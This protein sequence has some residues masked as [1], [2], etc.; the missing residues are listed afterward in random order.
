MGKSKYKTDISDLKSTKESRSEHNK[1]AQKIFIAAE[2]LFSEQGFTKTT[3]RQITS[4]A[5]VNV[6]AVNYHFHSKQGLIWAVADNYLNPFSSN[7][8]TLLNESL[9]KREEHVLK[10]EE[11]L[12]VLV[13]ALLKLGHSR[14]LSLPV[15]MRLL[16]LLYMKDQ[17]ELRA[18]FLETYGQEFSSFMRLLQ[19]STAI[20]DSEEFFWRLHFMLGSV[21]F[22]LSNFQTLVTIEVRQFERAVEIEKVLLRMIPVLAAGF[23]S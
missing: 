14:Q 6:A 10:V 7:L 20:S 9:V 12:E 8:N 23:K 13:R 5:N 1:T 16:E 21:I 17:E 19:Q 3:V 11:L 2:A 22:T 18:V 15:F 4:T